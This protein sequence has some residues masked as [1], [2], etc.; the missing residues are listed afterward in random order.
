ML[1]ESAGMPYNWDGSDLTVAEEHEDEVDGLFEQVHGTVEEDDEARYH[2]IEELFGAVD[3]LANDPGDEDRQRALLEAVGWSSCRRRWAWTMA[4]G[5][6]SAAR[7]MPWWPPSSTALVTT[8]FRVRRRC[9]PRCST[10]W[11]DRKRSGG[12]DAPASR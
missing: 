11:S 7:V 12:A 4:T 1:L 3:R 8:R 6:G 2:S 9:W 10:K 5:G